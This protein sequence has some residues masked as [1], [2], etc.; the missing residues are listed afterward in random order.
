MDDFIRQLLKS[1]SVIAIVAILSCG[2]DADND[3]ADDPMDNPGD[4]PTE[5]SFD[6]DIGDSEIPYIVINTDAAI[7]NEPKIPASL[8]IYVRK[9]EVIITSIGIEFRGSTS[10][11]I[12][13]K[14]SF[15]IETWDENGEDIDVSFFGFPEEEDWILNGHVVNNGG[16]FSYDQT[17]MYHYLGYNLFEAM[18]RYASRTQFVE[19]EIN[20]EYLGVY[21]F[22]EK[23]K[24][25]GDRIDIEGLSPDVIEGEDLTGGYVLK[26]DKTAGGDLN[27]DQPLSYFLNNWDDDARYLESTS[28]RSKYD[29]NGNVINFEPF[30]PPYHSQMFLET[31]FIYESPKAD[32]INDA[33]KAYI[34]NYID[35]LETA[36]LADDFSTGTRTYTNYIDLE[37]FVDFFIINEVCR[38]VDGYRL[39]TYM[40]KDRGGKLNMGPIWDL[41][42][43]FDSGVRIPFDD[44][45]INYNQHVSQDAWMMPFWW[46]RLMEDPIFRSTLKSRWNE[47]RASVLGTSSVIGLVDASANYLVSNGAIDRNYQK[48]NVVPV[49]YPERVQALKDFLEFRLNWMDGEIGAF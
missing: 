36:L 48:W 21:V 16:G 18:G 23:L 39:S 31:Y 35:E 34:Q 27:I 17:L 40:Y 24:R 11:R 30:G 3:P 41:N 6:V 22:M 28:F 10:F 47:L 20:G 4:D 38:N 33:Q 46:P 44:W 2:D 1:C 9:T 29:I 32:E 8:K 26:I 43:G 42:I 14:K 15:G 45:V 49:N 13:D 37:S 12:S 7:Q 5:V 19:L 25:D